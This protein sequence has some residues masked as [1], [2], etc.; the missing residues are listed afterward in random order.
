MKYQ[1][2]S[3]PR[4]Q[5][6][7]IDKDNTF[8]NAGNKGHFNQ[9]A[10]FCGWIS[11]CIAVAA[12]ADFRNDNTEDLKQFEDIPI[13]ELQE[14]RRPVETN[15]NPFHANLLHKNIARIHCG[16]C[17]ALF[18]S[19][20]SLR[21]HKKR[22]HP[23]HTVMRR[24]SSNHKKSTRPLF[25][26]CAES[27]LQ[28]IRNN[29]F[30]STRFQ[31]NMCKNS[32]AWKKDLFRHK[33]KHHAEPLTGGTKLKANRKVNKCRI[34]CQCDKCQCWFRDNVYMRQHAKSCNSHQ[35][36]SLDNVSLEVSATPD[37]KRTNNCDNLK[38]PTVE[39][40]M[41]RAVQTVIDTL[42]SGFTGSRGSRRKSGRKTLA[43]AEGVFKSQTV[44]NDDQVSSSSNM[45]FIKSCKSAEMEAPR[46]LNS[47]LDFICQFCNRKMKERVLIYL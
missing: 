44:L 5:L 32:Y 23:D 13:D 41:V 21:R 45:I 12:L 15:K 19:G 14:I 3:V 6:D 16:I 2:K 30:A 17:K 33:Q 42:N 35:D 1:T 25:K 22:L 20:S 46:K 18:S 28:G 31:C 47:T 36:D 39:T 29:S 26:T 24:V 9:K 7:R 34:P 43:T 11:S 40:N 8:Q 37:T 10:L 38:A 27:C 4:V